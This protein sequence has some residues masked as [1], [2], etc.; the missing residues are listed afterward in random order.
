MTMDANYIINYLKLTE[1]PEGGW[2]KETFQSKETSN[3]RSNSSL[4]YYLLKENEN[5]HWHRVTDADEIWLWHLGDPLLLSYSDEQASKEITLGPDLKNNEKLQAVI[6]KSVWQKAKSK[7]AWSL[8][9]C[10]VA[11]AFSFDGFEMAKKGWE[12]KT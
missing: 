3:G 12:P 10:V 9:S 4:I 1:H 5:S 6:P 2:F 8:V 11:P 7:G